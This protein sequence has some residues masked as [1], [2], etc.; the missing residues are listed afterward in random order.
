MNGW[1]YCKKEFTIPELLTFCNAEMKG[2]KFYQN[3][4]SKKIKCGCISPL[5]H[6]VSKYSPPL[7]ILISV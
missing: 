4:M 3:I 5:F 7:C 2:I 6:I 1:Y